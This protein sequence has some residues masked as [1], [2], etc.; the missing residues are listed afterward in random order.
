M[1][2]GEAERGQ[3]TGV[4]IPPYTSGCYAIPI[5]FLYG[6][7]AEINF[8]DVVYFR[9]H[10]SGGT[11]ETSTQELV[12]QVGLTRQMIG[13][14]RQAAVE[15]QE[16]I[17][18]VSFESGWRF[19]L[20]VSNF[21]E[22]SKGIVWKPLGY[23][24][25][26]W[27]RVVTPAIP[28][29]VLNLYFQQPRQRVYH[30]DMSYLINKCRRYFPYGEYRPVEPLKAADI[31][32]SLKLLLRLGIL[33]PEDDGYRI[34]WEALNHPAPAVPPTFDEPDPR[35]HPLFRQ[36]AELDPTRAKRALELIDIGQFDLEA[37]FADIFRDL[38]YVT[39]D[40]FGLLK[41]KVHVRRN[42]PPGATRWRDT[43]KAFLTER[44]RR[45]SE[46]RS[47]KIVVPLAT[48]GTVDIPLVFDPGEVAGRILAARFVARVE[49]PWHFSESIAVIL[50]LSANGTVLYHRT[51]YTGDTEIRC[52]VNFDNWP[53]WNE[54]LRLTV[55]CSSSAPGVHVEA[56]IEARLRR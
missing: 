43:W 45:A 39:S 55:L 32:K 46:I 5:R 7:A 10:Q 30:L 42:R 19:S 48:A 17:E 16:L 15:H 51:I 24:G 36:S 11:F 44:R 1:T 26:G 34:D 47:A 21:G 29:R 18:D 3:F 41:N 22:L 9:A 31:S 52:P 4:S 40:D 50:E 20:T 56:W 13:Q 6:S 14:L 8:W 54:P 25:N 28:K 35:G 2:I 12:E 38:L 37:S 49:W 33:F 53:D 27:H 23:V